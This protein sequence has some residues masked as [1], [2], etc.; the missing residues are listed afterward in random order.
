MEKSS[1]KISKNRSTISE[2]SIV[3][4]IFDDLYLRSSLDI[5]ILGN[6]INLIYHL[7]IYYVTIHIKRKKKKEDHNYI[8]SLVDSNI[9]DFTF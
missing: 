3:F 9:L 7:L 5:F 6:K 8:I 4:V 2:K 1:I